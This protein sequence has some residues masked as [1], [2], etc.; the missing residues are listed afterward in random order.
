MRGDD[1][2]ITVDPGGVG[3]RGGDGGGKRIGRCGGLDG[4]SGGIRVRINDSCGAE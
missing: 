1:S 2:G 3:S 4:R